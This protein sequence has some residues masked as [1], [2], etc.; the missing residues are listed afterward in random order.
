MRNALVKPREPESCADC[1]AA[2][3]APSGFFYANCDGCVARSLAGSPLAA[4]GLADA[5]T[6]TQE[7]VDRLK[8][9]VM[10]FFPPGRRKWAAAAVR[11]WVGVLSAQRSR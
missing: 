7:D 5:E 4:L 10:A 6:A 2:R 8:A 11:E 9:A 3:I 1:A